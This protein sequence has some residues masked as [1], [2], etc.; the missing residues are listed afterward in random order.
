MI[1]IAF[2]AWSNI[3]NTDGQCILNYMLTYIVH[4][5]QDSLLVRIGNIGPIFTP[6]PVLM[7]IGPIFTPLPVRIGNIGPIFTFDVCNTAFRTSLY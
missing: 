3:S 5:I 4:V 6:L 2:T 1:Y 7:N